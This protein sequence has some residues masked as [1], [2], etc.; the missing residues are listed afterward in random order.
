MGNSSRHTPKQFSKPIKK[1]DPEAPEDPDDTEDEGEHQQPQRGGQ[2]WE[3]MRSYWSEADIEEAKKATMDEAT[4]QDDGPFKNK[5]LH[6]IIKTGV[7]TTQGLSKFVELPTNW[8]IENYF[9]RVNREPEDRKAIFIL[10]PSSSG[11]T[12]VAAGLDGLQF[13]LMTVD[14][15]DWREVSDVWRQNAQT[16][17]RIKGKDCLFKDYFK[18]V[19]QTIKPQ[20]H[21]WMMKKI[22][23]YTPKTL[24]IPSTAV[25]CPM[26]SVPKLCKIRQDLIDPIQ[27]LGYTVSFVV[28]HA[29][30]DSV[31]QKGTLR[32]D[33]EGKKYS[34]DGYLF[35]Y[36]SVIR[37]M[38][39]YSD[40]TWTFFHNDF[41]G[42]P[43]PMDKPQYE[44]AANG[45]FT[46]QA[47]SVV[48][49]W[50]KNI[51]QQ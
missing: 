19:F 25:P 14:G 35:A 51:F 7:E 4:Q 2:C 49:R 30:K 18:E 33:K 39:H 36:V 16:K 29:E 21:K 27:N 6:R 5:L 42:P 17:H 26:P 47:V 22:A 43:D 44:E 34:S 48:K 23:Q 41:N 8:N 12:T 38:K 24:L 20:M 11:K 40:L 10:G 3:A 32:Q 9:K 45:I 31:V 1:G 37:L 15:A 50:F 46:P 28:I 13:P